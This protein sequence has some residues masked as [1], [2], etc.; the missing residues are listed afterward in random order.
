MAH[1]FSDSGQNYDVD[2]D[3]LQIWESASAI[4]GN[5]WT[6]DLAGGPHGLGGL[7]IQTNA[8]LQTRINPQG[9]GNQNLRFGQY[10]KFNTAPSGTKRLMR[11]GSSNEVDERYRYIIMRANGTIYTGEFN[12]TSAST[13][14]ASYNS[15]A[16]LTDGN[17]HFI[18]YYINDIG[19]NASIK[20]KIDNVAFVDIPSFDSKALGQPLIPNYT[21]FR[22]YGCDCDMEPGPTLIWDDVASHP[23]EMVGEIMGVPKVTTL[24]VVGPGSSA[25]FTPAGAPTNHECVDDDRAHD[26]DTAT[27]ESNIQGN[28]DLYTY[29]TYTGT[30]SELIAIVHNFQAKTEAGSNA[31]ANDVCLS[32]GTVE[33]RPVQTFTTDQY[34]RR[35][36]AY[37]NNPDTG[38]EWTPGEINAPVQAGQEVA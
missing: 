33:V 24:N 4:G 2:A 1:R 16:S 29:E 5:N 12:N 25:D 14:P 19:N 10:V 20:V 7:K 27:V 18:E 35:Q 36:T 32:G 28:R 23:N 37:A 17:W 13:G 11:F 31:N 26:D 22:L 6:V 3:I 9:A 30:P 15:T 34:K 21:E 8:F 38:N